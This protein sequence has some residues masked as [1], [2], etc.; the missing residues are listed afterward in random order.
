VPRN[1]EIKARVAD[2]A[3]LRQSVSTL[4]AAPGT[5]IEQA[6]TFFVVPRGRLKVREFADGSGELI[7]YDRPDYAGPKES[8]Y[9]RVPCANAAG[10]VRALGAVLPVR[11]QIRKRRE[12]F[13]VGRT[14]VHLDQVE[15][16]GSF[17]ELE[18]VLEDNEPAEAG[19]ADAQALM[20][21]LGFAPDVLVPGAYIDLLER[22]PE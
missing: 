21:T 1:L 16:L 5:V 4:A 8:V 17:A 19:K 7:V 18:V 15:R 20:R 9:T 14:R 22:D 12:A 10:L 6:D 11:G 13:I 2:L 3:A